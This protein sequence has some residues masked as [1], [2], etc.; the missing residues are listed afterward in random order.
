MKWKKHFM[1]FVPIFLL[2]VI[3]IGFGLVRIFVESL[4]SIPELSMYGYSFGVYGEILSDA[5]FMDSFGYSVYIALTSTLFSTVIGVWIG[6]SLVRSRYLFIKKFVSCIMRYGMILPYTYM[7][8]MV[9]LFLGRAGILS[10]ILYSLGVISVIDEFP[11]FLYND[12]AFGIILVFILKG[13]PFVTLFVLQVMGEISEDLEKVSKTLG[14]ESLVIFRKVYLQLS[15]NSIVWSSTV[16]FIYYLGSFEV[17]LLLSSKKIPLS[18]MLYGFYINPYIEIIPKA[19]A[20]NVV[21]FVIGS[22]GAMLYFKMLR[23]V[24]FWLGRV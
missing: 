17:P 19:M 1:W 21:L 16:L 13:I 2:Y 3:F 7:T 15:I 24:I 5:R 11:Q 10:R 20:M 9:V 8:F 6:Y 22:L 12:L 23:R 14:A 18:T 4:G